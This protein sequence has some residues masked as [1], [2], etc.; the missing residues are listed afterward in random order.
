[1]IQLKG[2]KGISPLERPDSR[3]TP[4]PPGTLCSVIFC[5][6]THQTINPSIHQ[7]IN[8]SIHQT[9]KPSNHQ[10]INPS[11]HQT[12][13]PSNHQTI[14]PSNHHPAIHQFKIFDN[15][16][17]SL[18]FFWYIF[19]GTYRSYMVRDQKVA[20]NWGVISSQIY[21]KKTFLTISLNL[22]GKKIKKVGFQ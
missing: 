22:Q 3:I 21:K 13:Q 10:T 14:N 15:T 7:T 11:I 6:E 17:S 8:P 18:I 19:S 12:I 1:M 20:R 4:P 16:L 9:I 5:P 2:T